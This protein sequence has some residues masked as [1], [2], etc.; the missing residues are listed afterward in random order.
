MGNFTFFLT[1]VKIYNFEK[2]PKKFCESFKINKL[3]EN[4][5]Q[6]FRIISNIF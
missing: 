4:S 6:V 2:I 3:E 5:E 1:A